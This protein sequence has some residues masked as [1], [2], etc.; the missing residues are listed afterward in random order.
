MVPCFIPIGIVHGNMLIISS[1]FALVVRSQSKISCLSRLSRM[2]P[3]TANAS[4]PF[5]F[6][7]LKI[8]LTSSGI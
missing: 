3:P 2:E 8:Y 6:N 1:G 7:N 5:S 4:N